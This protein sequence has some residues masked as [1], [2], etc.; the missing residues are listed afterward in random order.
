MNKFWGTS[1][2]TDGTKL[3]SADKSKMLDLLKAHGFK[4][5]TKRV[6]QDEL[7]WTNENWERS[8]AEMIVRKQDGAIFTPLKSGDSVIPA[9]L[10]SN[11]FKWGAINP[12]TVIKANGGLITPTNT[13]N[14]NITVQ[15]GSLLTVNGDVDREVLPD[16]QVILEKAYKYTSKELYKEAKKVGYRK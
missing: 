10:S 11:L 5:G 8:G 15:Y 7:A 12:S 3:K 9:N 4:R 6:S 13:N 1:F 2:N 14:S 16:L